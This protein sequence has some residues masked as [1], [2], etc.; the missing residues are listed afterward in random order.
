[1]YVV[2]V[3]PQFVDRPPDWPPNAQL[4]GFCPGGLSHAGVPVEIEEF[5]ADGDPPVLVTLG[6]APSSTSAD[7][8][9]A[10]AAALDAR[11]LRALFLVGRDDLVSGPLRDRAGVATFAPLSEVLPRCRAAIHAGG[12]GTTAHALSAGIPSLVMPF[13][14]DQLWYARR[15]A[16]LGAGVVLS[17]RRHRHLD[18]LIDQV[19]APDMLAT[20]QRLA[21]TLRAHDGVGAT[22]DAFERLLDTP[23]RRRAG[24]RSG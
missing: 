22:C 4:S 11:G 17:A 3:P 23:R 19:M 20:T 13:M 21:A 24:N 8:F 9:A 10:V 5:L 7:R 1:L 6:S 18:Q 16:A 14:P 2:P 12:Y 15:T